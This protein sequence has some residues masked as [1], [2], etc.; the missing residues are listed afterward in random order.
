MTYAT[1]DELI[2][3]CLPE[4]KSTSEREALGRFLEAASRAIDTLTKRPANYYAPAAAQPS[5]RNFRGEG[6]NYLRIP[7]H[8]AGSIDATTGVQVGGHPLT[9]WIE[10]DQ[11]GWLYMTHGFGSLGGV[12]V[13]GAL[14]T[15]FARW[16]YE[17]TPADIVLVCKDLTAH[18]FNKHRGVIGQ[19]APSGFVIERDAPP[20]VKPILA[21]YKRKEFELA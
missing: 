11:G 18:Y 5:P 13:R 17:E 10:H 14:Y 7:V 12:W 16:G 6:T 20:T 8:V 21:Q 4:V 1:L 9:N 15:V 19:I 2:K 3:D